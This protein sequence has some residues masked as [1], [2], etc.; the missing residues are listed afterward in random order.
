MLFGCGLQEGQAGNGGEVD[1][2]DVGVVRGSPL[3]RRLGVPEFFFQL[4]GGS[5]VGDAFGA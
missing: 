1:R 2:R 5:G 4:A 3:L